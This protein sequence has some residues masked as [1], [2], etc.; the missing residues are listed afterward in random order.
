MDVS[1]SGLISPEDNGYSKFEVSKEYIQKHKPVVGGYYVVYED[2]Y[3]SFSPAE[4]FESGNTLIDGKEVESPGIYGLLHLNMGDFGQAVQ[5]LKYGKKVS[6]SGWNGV[7]MFLYLAYPKHK[8]GRINEAI[9]FNHSFTNV[10]HNLDNFIVMK[11]AGNT[12]VPWLA[13]QTDML[14][15]DWGIVE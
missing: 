14:A 12:L 2:G 15:Q 11:T 1:G 4:A 13:S 8:D 10:N 5:A 6:R 9:M 7:N 3:E